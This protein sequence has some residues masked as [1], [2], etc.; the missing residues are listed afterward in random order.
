[1]EMK[2]WNSSFEGTV[3]PSDPKKPLLARDGINGEPLAPFRDEEK[4]MKKSK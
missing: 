3:A 2:K 1:M 4:Q